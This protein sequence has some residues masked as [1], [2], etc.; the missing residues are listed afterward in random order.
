MGSGQL[1]RDQ[2]A[3]IARCR[4]QDVI[5]EIEARIVRHGTGTGADHDVIAGHIL[6]DE[7]EILAAGEGATSPRT[8]SALTVSV[9]TASAMGVASGSFTSGTKMSSNVISALPS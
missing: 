3:E 8:F 5:V 4:G 6:D 7:G 2:A 1:R 9:A